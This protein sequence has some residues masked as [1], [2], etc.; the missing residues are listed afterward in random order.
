M[1]NANELKDLEA[2]M[3]LMTKYQ[4][5][6]VTLPSGIIITKALHLPAKTRQRASKNQEAQ[7]PVNWTTSTPDDILFAQ[8]SAPPITLEDFE[9]FTISENQ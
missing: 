2:V 5:D 6:Q 3:K 4:V 1:S 9:N 7:L 8:S